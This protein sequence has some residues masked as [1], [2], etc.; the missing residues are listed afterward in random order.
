MVLRPTVIWSQHFKGMYSSRTFCPLKISSF[1]TSEFDYS[2]MHHHIT[3]VQTPYDHSIQ[4]TGV[5]HLTLVSRP[6]HGTQVHN[7]STY[8]FVCHDVPRN[9]PTWYILLYI[10]TFHKIQL[11][12]TS[13]FVCNKDIP[14]NTPVWYILLCMYGLHLHDTAYSVRQYTVYISHL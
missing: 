3:E 1:I 12:D 9:T 8:C 6:F 14:L 7:R 13:Y 2:V 10:M 11:Y 4:Y 5:A